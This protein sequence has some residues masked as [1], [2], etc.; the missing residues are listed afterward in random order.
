MLARIKKQQRSIR[1]MKERSPEGLAQRPAFIISFLCRGQEAK[2]VAFSFVEISHH[3][4][5]TF[6]ISSSF[7]CQSPASFSLSQNK[8]IR[9][10]PSGI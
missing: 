7:L 6:M 2:D 8:S 3:L 1:G 9:Y 10:S 5:D 4:A